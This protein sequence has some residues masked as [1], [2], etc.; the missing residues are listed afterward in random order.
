MLR[1]D[2][3]NLNGIWDFR[4]DFGESGYEEEA[5]LGKGF[6]KKINVPFA[7]ES[8]L[9]GIGYTGF[10][11]SVWYKRTVTVP[12][13]FRDYRVILHFGA[14]DYLASVYVNGMLAGEHR[15]GY[16]PFKIDITD[17]LQDGENLLVVCAKDNNRLGLQPRGKQASKLYS[18]GCDYT[19]TTGIWQ[20]VYL[21]YVKG[22]FIDDLHIIPDA[23]NCSVKVSGVINKKTPVSRSR[24]TVSAQVRFGGETV[25]EAACEVSWGRFDLA[26]PIG[27]K[28]LWDMGQGNLYD[29]T[30]HYRDDGRSSDTVQTYFGLR[31]IEIGDGRVFLNGR[32]IF[33]RLVL[34]QG[35]YKD[36][37]YTA[38][39]EALLRRDIELSMQLGFNGARMHQK[40]FEPRY[41]YYADKLG[42]L[43]W[44]EFGSW[45]LNL[46]DT[47]WKNIVPQW[48]EAVK[49]DRNHPSIITW[50]PLNETYDGQDRELL[51]ALYRLTH[52]LDGTR[53]VIDTSGYIHVVTDIYDTHDYV[54][55][56]DEYVERY[57]RDELPINFPGLEK[58]EG[59]P[60][61]VS[62]YGGMWWSGSEV[63]SWGYGQRPKSVD[64]FM[65]RFKGLTETLLNC[66]KVCG[67]CYTQLYDVEQET[68]GLLD[69]DRN[70][71]FS[72]ETI[73]AILTQKA[74]IEE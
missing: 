46:S 44:A 67:F 22:G 2:W 40:V 3:Q 48:A 37:I 27:R 29:L 45:G 21:E 63:E 59:Q 55:D 34:D 25:G 50:C 11:N 19:R 69:Y 51:V 52:D 5:H 47:G 26:I 64:E 53:P 32:P 23:L 73:S 54:Q 30:L 70:P 9:S 33:Q 12:E 60:F 35:Y 49:R 13:Q 1:K 42:Y 20:T 72:F 14:V 74:K 6:D 66:E 17:L 18:S 65:A 41:L 31:D 36:G 39:D 58:Y 56:V 43:T 38:Q 68:N 4:F 28:V 16:T 10:M 24:G 62:E 71:K 61:V 57:S 8:T 7:P 15:G